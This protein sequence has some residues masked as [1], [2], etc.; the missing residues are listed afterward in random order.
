MTEPIATALT[1]DPDLRARLSAA[2]VNPDTGMATD[3]LNHFNEVSMLIEMSVDMPEMLEEAKG[4]RPRS[5]AEH[6][7]LS[8]F[9]EAD[10]IIRAYEQAAP[11]LK[12][13]FDAHVDKL[14]VL[15]LDTIE[16]VPQMSD[17]ARTYDLPLIIADI[18]VQI[19]RLYALINGHQGMDQAAVDEELDQSDIDSLFD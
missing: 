6:F 2:N 9:T 8:G 11:D 4:W 14:N 12:T 15:I 16:R 13:L 10:L 3:Y 19:G 1:L 5:Y 7:R 17:N 18:Q